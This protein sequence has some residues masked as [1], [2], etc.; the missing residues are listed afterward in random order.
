MAEVQ[1]VTCGVKMWGVLTDEDP[2]HVLG[3]V[4]TPAATRAKR[5]RNKKRAA[6]GDG[7]GT[8]NVEASTSAAAVGEENIAAPVP[9]DSNAEAANGGGA[10]AA[11][12]PRRTLGRRMCKATFA[13]GL[14]AIFYRV[15]TAPSTGRLI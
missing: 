9:N 13:M 5:R 10:P 6:A 7:A 8:P 15:V 2:G 1:G 11:G 3:T 14:C 4:G 12:G